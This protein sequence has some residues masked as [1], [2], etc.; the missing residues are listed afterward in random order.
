[1]YD[2]L[3]DSHRKTVRC[4]SP[5]ESKYII[6]ENK[7]CTADLANPSQ[8]I[9]FLMYSIASSTSSLGSGTKALWSCK[10]FMYVAHRSEHWWARR[11]DIPVRSTSIQFLYHYKILKQFTSHPN[12]QSNVLKG[13]SEYPYEHN[14]VRNGFAW[15]VRIA[16]HAL[17]TNSTTP[18]L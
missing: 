11:M 6:P 18:H 5:I 12:N 9:W 8:S 16:T 2:E 17:A 14:C 15:A 13:L 7:S 4:D 3:V 1:M 10:L